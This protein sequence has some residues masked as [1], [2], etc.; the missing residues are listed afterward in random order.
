VVRRFATIDLG[1]NTALLLVAERRGGVW[2]PVV[3]RAEITRL[4]QGVDGSRRLQPE[5]MR[6]S[7]VAL[8]RYAEEARALGVLPSD[9]AAV[10]TSAA[11]DAANRSELIDSVRETAGIELEIIPGELEADLTCL[12]ATIG[13][14]MANA[15]QPIAVFDIGGGSSELIF[16]TRDGTRDGT[17]NGTR[18]R[19]DFSHS[20]DV[21]SV[22]LT[23]R[24]LHSDPPASDETDALFAHLRSL[25]AQAPRPSTPP[26][27]VGVA[28]TV[29][30]L[31]T[32]LHEIEPYDAARV[33][34]ARMAF[35]ELRCLRERLFA[36]TVEQRKALRGI[37]PKRADV[38]AA[39]A[40]ILEC[41][42]ERVGVEHLIVSDRGLRW[43][44]LEERFGKE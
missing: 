19:M 25:F 20:F 13:L 24:F 22:R 17:R 30:T 5:A 14:E 36:L 9:I 12:G 3:E 8:A 32:I 10:S 21:G 33:H 38:I 37:E 40:A 39:G 4:G 6:R 15:D 2:D 26:T 43:G 31:F 44:L 11:R 35:S 18:D 28:G 34:G 7:A 1:T 23:E 41:A 27:F 29:T 16:G 42:M